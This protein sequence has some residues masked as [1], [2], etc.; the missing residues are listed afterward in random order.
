MGSNSCFFLVWLKKIASSHEFATNSWYTWH[1]LR[2]PGRSMRASACASTWGFQDGSNITIMDA[3]C[4]LIPAPPT[5]IWT[6]R[7]CSCDTVWLSTE[8]IEQDWQQWHR[9]VVC[10]CSSLHGLRQPQGFLV[11]AA[12]PC[13]RMS[14]VNATSLAHPKLEKTIFFSKLVIKPFGL[15]RGPSWSALAVCCSGVLRTAA[16]CTNQPWRTPR[17]TGIARSVPLMLIWYAVSWCQCRKSARK[18]WQW[19]A[20]HTTHTLAVEGMTVSHTVNTEN[21]R[22][23]H[24]ECVGLCH[25]F[26][27]LSSWF[28]PIYCIYLFFSSLSYSSLVLSTLYSILFS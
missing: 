22:P 1:A 7:S 4:K 20:A 28:P 12:L 13:L 8:G 3:V 6:R 24:G 18:S 17:D 21:P 27:Q 19:C 14:C 23:R 15:C 25:S 2:W 5:F 10:C 9:K 26:L 16:S 11:A